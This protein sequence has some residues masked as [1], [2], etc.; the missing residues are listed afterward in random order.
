[1]NEN[2]PHDAPRP[3]EPVR[4]RKRRGKIIAVAASLVL[5]LGLAAGGSWWFGS[6]LP[7]QHAAQV[8]ASADA[9]KQAVAQASKDAAA[10]KKA[11][12][13]AAFWAKVN[14]NQVRND[15]NAKDMAAF[16]SGPSQTELQMK[17]QGWTRFSGDLYYQ[18]ADKSE[19]SCGYLPC[20][21]IHVTT[22]AADV[23]PGGIYVGASLERGGSSIGLA[24]SI[25]AALTTGKDAIVKLEDTTRQGDGIKLTTLTCH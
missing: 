24:N 19:Y 10:K 15:Q 1:M 3:D 22:L 6:A 17:A 13:S 12:D 11:D 7:A 2:N 21:Y 16:N 8:Q 4:P 5:V 25:T 9:S 18:S 20:T 23:C 14:A